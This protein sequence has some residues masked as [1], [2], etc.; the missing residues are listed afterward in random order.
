MVNFS[1]MPNFQEVFETHLLEEAK[2]RPKW[3]KATSV[4]HESLINKNKS[5][6]HIA[7]PQG[8]KPIG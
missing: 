8:N 3:E 6:D 7:P 5:W 4:E 2:W 1:L